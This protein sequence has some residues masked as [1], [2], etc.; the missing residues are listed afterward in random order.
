MR[1][2]FTE[3]ARR[4]FVQRSDKRFKHLDECNLENC[5]SCERIKKEIRVRLC[6]NRKSVN[7]DMASYLGNAKLSKAHLNDSN[8]M[9]YVYRRYGIDR[10]FDFMVSGHLV[11]VVV[12]GKNDKVVVTVMDLKRNSIW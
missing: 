12:Y 5:P 11:F 6:D 4:R 1:Y 8:F 7:R 10:K 2:S 9:D 3:H